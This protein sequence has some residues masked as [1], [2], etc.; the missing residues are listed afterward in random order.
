MRIDPVRETVEAKPKP[1][2]PGDPRPVFERD[3]GGP[4]GLG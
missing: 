3:V 2:Q 4:Y 1:P